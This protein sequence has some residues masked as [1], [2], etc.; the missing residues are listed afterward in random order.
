[1]LQYLCTH[2]VTLPTPHTQRDKAY[3]RDWTQRGRVKVMIR[4]QVQEGGVT[5]LVPV[6]PE[7]PNSAWFLC[8]LFSASLHC[9]HSIFICTGD[10][11]KISRFCGHAHKLAQVSRRQIADTGRR[12]RRKR[13][14]QD[15]PKKEEKVI[16][17]FKYCLGFKTINNKNTSRT[18][19][20]HHKR[21]ILHHVCR[22][23]LQIKVAFGVSPMSC[24]ANPSEL[25][26]Y[27]RRG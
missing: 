16:M 27:T 24:S 14:R 11:E 15:Q 26:S 4:K 6:N 3:S 19:S 10:R 22:F 18:V 7:I 23:R 21:P 25:V 17:R 8:S 9:S 2:V 20:Q 5:K 1:M 13:S 12:A